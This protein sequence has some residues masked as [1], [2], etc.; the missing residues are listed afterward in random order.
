MSDNIYVKHLFLRV[1]HLRGL[2]QH[3]TV[4]YTKLNGLR[5]ADEDK[6]AKKLEWLARGLLERILIG[7]W[8]LKKK[9]RRRRRRRS[10]WV[11]PVSAPPSS[12]GL[13]PSTLAA[14]LFTMLR[15]TSKGKETH[16]C[17]IHL[18]CRHAVPDRQQPGAKRISKQNRRFWQ[19]FVLCL[20]RFS[21]TLVLFYFQDNFPF[22]TFLTFIFFT[23]IFSS[24][25]HLVHLPLCPRNPPSPVQLLL[26]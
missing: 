12:S 9:R 5:H 18:L 22:F 15:I 17:T 23:S 3:V 2:T 24:L 4:N 20:S 11:P 13:P 26:F 16:K 10:V 25:S 14:M 7:Y 19:L 21:L 6:T 1:Q 8:H